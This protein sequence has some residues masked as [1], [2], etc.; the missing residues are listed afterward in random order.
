MKE[1]LYGKKVRINLGKLTEEEQH[2]YSRHFKTVVCTVTKRLN[3]IDILT[4]YSAR[5]SLQKNEDVYIIVDDR[6]QQAW[7]RESI[8]DLVIETGA[9]GT[10][11]VNAPKLKEINVVDFNKEHVLQELENFFETEIYYKDFEF[12]YIKERKDFKGN[13]YAIRR[14]IVS[15]YVEF[16]DFDF[17]YDDQKE[18][19]IEFRERLPIRIIESLLR[20]YNSVLGVE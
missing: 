6:G 19:L 18:T 8:L 13:T 20:F 15:G 17:N 14:I 5:S 7:A 2:M 10:V 1:F 16:D 12:Y 11:K 3:V 4:R 9:S